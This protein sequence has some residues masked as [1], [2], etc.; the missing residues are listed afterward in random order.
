M[1]GLAITTVKRTGLSLVVVAMLAMWIYALVFSPRESI[2][3][4]GDG[5]WADRAELLCINAK[6]EIYELADYRLITSD[7]DLAERASLVRQA[8]SILR[9]MVSR[10]ANEEPT[11]DKGQAIVPLWLAD[12][13]TYL[14]DRDDYAA[15]LEKGTNA[16]FAET[17]VDGLP[18]SEKITTFANDNRMPAC[19]PPRDL[20]V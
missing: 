15:L 5:A 4:I 16:P 20:S 12:Y 9:V 17:Q 11:D 14:S 13:R 6:E 2:N 7:S 1:P 18:L 19:S 8:T 10:I 3:K